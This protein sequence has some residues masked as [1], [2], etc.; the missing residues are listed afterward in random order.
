MKKIQGSSDRVEIDLHSIPKLS[1]KKKG[2]LSWLK[3]LM[4]KIS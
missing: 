2:R 1:R 4:K 3:E